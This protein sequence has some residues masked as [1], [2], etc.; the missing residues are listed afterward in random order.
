MPSR[1]WRGLRTESVNN[2]AGVLISLDEA[3]LYSHSARCG[4]TEYE[5]LPGAEENADDGKDT[6]SQ[7]MLEMSAAEYSIAG[8]RREVRRGAKG[9]TS[10]YESRLSP[11]CSSS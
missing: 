4:R 6:E 7:G 8:L 2:Y 10:S 11:C 1:L 3:H 9:S 5:E